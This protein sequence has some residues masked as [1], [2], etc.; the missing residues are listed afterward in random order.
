MD[1]NFGL[2]GGGFGGMGGGLGGGM[3]MGGGTGGLP[4]Q[5]QAALAS[6]ESMDKRVGKLSVKYSS[7]H[8]DH[9]CPTFS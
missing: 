5:L 8:E 3:D 4:P 1:M 2:G 6:L 7:D 9:W